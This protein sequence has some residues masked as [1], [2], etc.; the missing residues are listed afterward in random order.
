M[1]KLLRTI[2]EIQ[3]RLKQIEEKIQLKE[4][5]RRPTSFSMIDDELETLILIRNELKWVLEEDKTKPAEQYLDN[6]TMVI[7]GH[8]EN[9]KKLTEFQYIENTDF[10]YRIYFTNKEQKGP[11]FSFMVFEAAFLH[12]D[13]IQDDD[14][15]IPLHLMMHGW[16]A[17]DGFRHVWVNDGYFHYA[18]PDMMIAIWNDLK[19]LAIQFG[20]NED[21]L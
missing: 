18:S 12:D 9:E 4:K 3:V 5:Q 1:P 8:K 21:D 11:N 2:E 10:D 14:V 19:K 13:E 17:S 15:K 6:T 16:C 7:F 20:L